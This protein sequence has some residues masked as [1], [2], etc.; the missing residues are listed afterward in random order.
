MAT[1]PVEKRAESNSG[2]NLKVLR[3]AP[4]LLTSPGTC[5]STL[6]MSLVKVAPS[7]ENIRV[8]SA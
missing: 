1:C 7:D 4:T 2:P 3:L 6:E 8:D 5:T